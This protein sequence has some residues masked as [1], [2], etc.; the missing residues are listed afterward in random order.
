MQQI[1]SPSVDNLPKVGYYVSKEEKKKNF[2]ENETHIHK[3]GPLSGIKAGAHKL[4][5]DI[6]TYFPKGFQGSKNSDFY[7]YLS[8]GMV[9]YLIGSVLMFSTYKGANKFFNFADKME[10]NSVARGVGAGVV[11]YGIGKWASKKLARTLI[12]ASTGVNLNLQY[13]KKIN[14]LPEQGQEEGLVRVQYPGVFDSPTFYR[15]DLL[16]K[17]SDLVHNNIFWYNDK[18]AKKAGFKE[19]LN[20]PGQTMGPK[21]KQLKT[22]T[23]A[24][25]NIMQYIPAACGVAFG[26]QKGFKDMKPSKIFSDKKFNIGNLKGNLTGLTKAFAESFVQLWQGTDRNLVTKHGGKALMIG[27]VVATLLTWLIPTIA[28]KRNPDPMKSQVDT[29]KE[30]EVC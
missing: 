19:P 28:F 15:S 20:A 4:T 8:L 2:Y 11:M 3:Q 6:F 21:I 9:P 23:T 10:A 17:Y 27:S 1:K 14:E 7:E 16:D 26:F 24:L 5:N 18:I 25:E 30:Y 29:K 12:H 13:L 22:R